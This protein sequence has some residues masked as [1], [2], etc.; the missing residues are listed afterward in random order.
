MLEIVIYLLLLFGIFLAGLVNHL[1]WRRRMIRLRKYWMEKIGKVRA[2]Y[3]VILE[4]QEKSF[5]QQRADFRRREKLMGQK[6]LEYSKK[7][8]ELSAANEELWKKVNRDA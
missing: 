2:E 3:E 5:A 6:I 7:L 1:R 8:R 4:S